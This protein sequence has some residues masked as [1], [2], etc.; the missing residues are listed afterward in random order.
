MRL[1]GHDHGE[2]TRVRPRKYPIAESAVA[3]PPASS[4]A[5]EA[6]EEVVAKAV[7]EAGAEKDG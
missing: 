7:K 6:A 2:V 3:G 4:D 1:Q 5:E